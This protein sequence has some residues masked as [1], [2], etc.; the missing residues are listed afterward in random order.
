MKRALVFCVV[1][2]VV[3]AVFS[4]AS[5]QKYRFR[6]AYTDAPRLP[7]GD[8]KLIHVTVAAVY[9]FEDA[10]NSLT[11]GAFDVDFKHSAVLGGQVET[12]E[13]V[14]DGVIEATTPAI[15]ALAGY[16]P[17]MQIL[18]I[19]YLWKSP[20]I[21][22]EV[23]DGDFGKAFFDD[24][25]KKTGLRI[26]TIFDNG[27]YRSFTN[28]VREVRTARDMK[29]IKIRTMESPA[30]MKIVSSLG[31][32]PTPIPWVELYTSLQTGVVDGEENSAATIIAGSLYEV[33]KYYTIDQ[34]TLSLAVFVVN[35][36]WFQDLPNDVKQSVVVAGKVASICGRGAANANNKLAMEFL[37][38]YGMQIYFPTAAE[39]DT[40]RKAAQPE[41]LD[42]MR[43][44][45][46]IENV[47][48]DR[49]LK[50]VE[51]AERKYGFR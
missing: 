49:L 41:V 34:H 14:R 12:I 27:G 7:I 16:Y 48:I 37:K 1:V 15:P 11:G 24:M 21:A 47:W 17:N 39:R 51:Q 45:K 25:A 43:K 35:E 40:F 28:N 2:F 10:I 9:G 4:T 6:V 36:K 33:Q 19:P 50:A 5:A 32:A 3:L 22:W 30:Q 8:E 18:S 26:I 42:W 44:N 13:Q 29:G 20:V 23:F 38:N 46:K 31:G